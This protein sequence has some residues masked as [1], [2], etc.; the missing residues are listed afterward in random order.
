[1][2]T[3]DYLGMRSCGSLRQ[4]PALHL[5][6]GKGERI[7]ILFRDSLSENCFLKVQGEWK[8]LHFYD[9]PKELKNKTSAQLSAL[10]QAAAL[11]VSRF[12]NGDHRLVLQLGLKGGVFDQEIAQLRAIGGYQQIIAQV[13]KEFLAV[14]NPPTAN[15][16][17]IGAVAGVG[18]GA[19]AVALLSSAPD[20]W[21]VTGARLTGAVALGACGW[22]GV[23][24]MQSERSPEAR[25]DSKK[26]NDIFQIYADTQLNLAKGNTAAA[27][28]GSVRL[29]QQL[30]RDGYI[31]NETE[32]TFDLDR[33]SFDK[34][35]RHFEST[36]RASLVFTAKFLVLSVLAG[37]PV[38]FGKDRG[39][40]RVRPTATIISQLEAL[41]DR[42]GRGVDE[43]VV[44]AV[45]FML[46][47]L[48]Q[49]SSREIAQLRVVEGYSQIIAQIE[50]EF[51]AVVNSPA[52]NLL[53]IGVGFNGEAAFGVFW[54]NRKKLNDIF[55]VYAD[56]QLNLA[57]GNTAAANAGSVGL[58]QQL[59]RDGY[60]KNE[61][62]YTF[63]LDRFSFDKLAKHFESNQ[64]ASLVFTAKFLVLSVL[65][66][67]PAE[68]G[69]Q[70]RQRVR[71]I[72]NLIGHLEALVDQ[73]GRSIDESV[74]Q[75][76]YFIMGDL[77]YQ[78]QCYGRAVDCFQRIPP[79]IPELH[80]SACRMV[81]HISVLQ[82]GS[83]E[84]LSASDM[85]QELAPGRPVA[86]SSRL[87][88]L[89]S[90]PKARRQMS[91]PDY[92]SRALSLYPGSSSGA[93]H[94]EI[95]QLKAVEGCHQSITTLERD[96]LRLSPA[97]IGPAAA[98]LVKGGV[99]V[100]AGLA[101]GGIGVGT[102]ALFAA[103]PAGWAVL[104][105][106]LV[107]AAAVGA[108]GWM[109]ASDRLDKHNA[110]AQR[111]K[112]LES[113]FERYADIQFT[114]AQG[115]VLAANAK[116]IKFYEQLKGN[117][118]IKNAT[119]YA[120]DLD[121]RAFSN[122]VN[123]FEREKR[124]AAL[125]TVKFLILSVLAGMPAEF[126][127]GRARRF[128]PTTAIIAYFEAL[129][130]GVERGV[131]ERLIHAVYFILGDLLYR[132]QCYARAI[133]YLQRIPPHSAELYQGAR[134]MVAEIGSLQM[135]F[136]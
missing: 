56:T 74:V 34:L 4:E 48:T 102:V 43:P 79:C 90:A 24:V 86:S 54:Q 51:L 91:Q 132:T 93:F 66:G 81:A 10:L 121:E 117:G 59:R 33:F 35:A 11:R 55:K 38:E 82:N 68:F 45:Y 7:A 118:Y 1:M 58:Y 136:D 125:F 123:R 70:G 53:K 127:E 27:N 92:G 62:E 116:S 14:V 22:V 133:A 135:A 126:L 113:V 80:Q 84:R 46:E 95:A 88:Q 87:R 101:G 23:S 73:S 109:F 18:L 75:A 44:Q 61:T 120:F 106:G 25:Q 3:T 78:T 36:Q 30:R 6:T 9:L 64:R 19:S 17:R 52:T 32:H 42:S 110:E 50:R 47:Q 72:A 41:I 85:S 29:Y 65:A 104:G 128:R 122:L 115:D 89:D 77:L 26:L 97:M 111:G 112:E 129:I 134:Q 40:Q 71:P 31:K 76:V 37:L 99:A 63:D 8:K 94:R 21:L 13:E 108:C 57:K 28:A 83:N 98:R 69:D 12:D 20:G 105:A 130:D 15:L 119:D 103:N 39:R 60:I 100:G 96:F 131:E 107:G 2:E 49:C 16:L 5:R 67:L 124:A 114:L